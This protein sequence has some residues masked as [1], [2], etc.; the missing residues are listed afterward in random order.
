MEEAMTPDSMN[1]IAEHWKER[2]SLGF[3]EYGDLLVPERETQIATLVRLLPADAAEAFTVLELG[4]GGGALARA[5]LEAYPQL[6]YVGLDA[7]PAML[8]HLRH[9]LAPFGDRVELRQGELADRGW[10]RSLPGPFRGVLSSLVVHHLDGPGKRRLF[11]DLV[12]ELEPGG[13]LL[14]ADI[15]EPETPQAKELYAQQWEDAVRRRSLEK[16]GDLAGYD[17]FMAEEWNYFRLDEDP[18][19]HPSTLRDQLRWMTSAG[20]RSAECFWLHAGHAIF[21]G[22]R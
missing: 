5:L 2:D 6:H 1:S 11:R 12:K 3:L 21:G 17:F 20:L 22:Y 4:P 19:D 18:I 10:R 7:S 8:D 9:T 15:V 14:I 16:R 13:G